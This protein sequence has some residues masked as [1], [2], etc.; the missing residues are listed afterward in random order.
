MHQVISATYSFTQIIEKFIQVRQ[1]TKA[2]CQPLAIEDYLPQPMVDVSPAKWH[3]AHTTWFFETFLLKKFKS[4]YKVF[5]PAFNELFNSYYNT[6]GNRTARNMRGSLSRPTVEE[7][8]TYRA[9]VEEHMLSLE[10]YITEKNEAEAIQLIEIGCQHEQQHQELLITDL[11]YILY[12]NVIR[13]VYH[14]P[15]LPSYERKQ[16]V[17]SAFLTVEEGVYKIGYDGNGFCFD[18]ELGVHQVFL[19]SFGIQNRLVTNG[20]YLEFMKDGGYTDFRL[21]LSEGWELVNKEEWRNPLYWEKRDGGWTTFS[22]LGEIEIDKQAPVTHLS[23]FE[24]SAYASWAGKRLLT[25]FEWEVAANM[26]NSHIRVENSQEHQIFHPLPAQL[27]EELKCHQLFGEMW[28]WTNSA[29]LPYPGFS[30]AEGALGEYNGKF[31]MNQM[32]LRG[33]SC[34]TPHN[35]MRHTYRNFFPPNARWQFAGIRLAE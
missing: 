32:V 31:M 33:S 23:F 29:Y 21:W 18:N 13:P 25:E 1:A 34:A 9:Y 7:V 24:A 15:V 5:H 28:Q 2:I 27:Q 12:C 19:R 17:K 20:E 8:Y 35:H 3:L 6:I 4:S 16:E 10:Q 14:T 22:L 30:I 11:K 26:F